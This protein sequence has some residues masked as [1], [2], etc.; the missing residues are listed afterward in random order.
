ERTVGRPCLSAWMLH[1]NNRSSREASQLL[2]FFPPSF[3]HPIH[4]R[5]RNGR[6]ITD[7][8]LANR[9]IKPLPNLERLQL[10]TQLMKKK[11]TEDF[12]VLWIHQMPI[13]NE[14]I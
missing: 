13:G 10:G 11:V 4:E 12:N 8:R 2:T 3:F 5:L 14:R 7:E 6:K 9:N 1:E